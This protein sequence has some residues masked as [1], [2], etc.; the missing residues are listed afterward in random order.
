MR[1]PVHADV[2][3]RPGLL[4]RPLDH[5]A[6]VLDR[7]RRVVVEHPARA[8]GAAHVHHD[9]RVAAAHVEVEIA[10]LHVA[11]PER[12]PFRQH[13]HRLRGLVEGVGRDQHRK[14]AAALGPENVRIERRA[15]AHRDAHVALDD[16]A[17]FP[18][19][20]LPGLREHLDSP[21]EFR[22]TAHTPADA[23]S[24]DLAPVCMVAPNAA[25]VAPFERVTETGPPGNSCPT[26]E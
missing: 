20:G 22:V 4:R 8:E 25:A 2:A 26:C 12:K 11:A 21:F 19:R 24:R 10:R 16:D 17:V 23:A 3:V 14:P 5:F 15:V 7:A 13:L 9:H 1:Y 18:G 6:D